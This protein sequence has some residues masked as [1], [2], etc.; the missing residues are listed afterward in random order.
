MMEAQVKFRKHIKFCR[1]MDIID[2]HGN[3]LNMITFFTSVVYGIDMVVFEFDRRQAV[4]F[5][6]QAVGDLRLV[7]CQWVTLEDRSEVHD[8][9]SRRE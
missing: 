1:T 4:D 7:R 5:E 9:P 6:D 8:L 3:I 2:I